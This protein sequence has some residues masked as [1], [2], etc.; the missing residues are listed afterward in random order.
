LARQGDRT[1]KPVAAIVVGTQHAA[2]IVTTFRPLSAPA[3]TGTPEVGKTLTATPATLS[4]APDSPATG[5][6]YAGTDALGGQTGATLVL[7]PTMVGKKISYKSTAVRGDETITSTSNELGP[8]S[9]VA[10]ATTLTVA[11][12]TGAYGTARTALAT[13]T[14]AGGTATGTVTFKVGSTETTVPLTGGAATLALPTNLPV[15]TQSVTAS[16]QG[17]SSTAASTSAAASVTVTKAASKV[18]AK[19]KAA[20]KTKKVA[21]KVTLTIT[22]KTAAGVSPAGKVTVTLKG[23]KKVTANVNAKGKATVTFKKVKRGKHKAT[24]S[25]AGNTTVRSAKTTITVKA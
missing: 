25:Y 18:T 21:K 16:Y 4:L 5:Q 9:L 12:V 8:V 20:G 19:A 24:V 3:I 17:D 7:D 15:G 11:P 2:V 23:S 1:G 13:V 14:R 22:V 10:S 6:W